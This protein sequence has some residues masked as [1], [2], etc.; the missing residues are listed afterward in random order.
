MR[1]QAAV[2]RSL[3]KKAPCSSVVRPSRTTCLAGFS[4]NSNF[5]QTGDSSS[6]RVWRFGMLTL[7]RPYCKLPRL[8]PKYCAGWGLPV[9]ARSVA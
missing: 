3:S 5:H 4:L 7:H 6:P 1:L 8:L 9:R 2:V